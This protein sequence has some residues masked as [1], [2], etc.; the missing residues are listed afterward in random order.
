[1]RKRDKRGETS[2]MGAIVAV[3]IVVVVGA[4]VIWGFYKY[5]KPISEIP[6][7]TL[8]EKQAITSVCDTAGKVGELLKTAYCYQFYKVGDKYGNCDYWKD[9]VDFE[10]LGESCNTD[11][12]QLAAT[13]FCNQEKLST[14]TKLNNKIC[15]DW[16]EESTTS[17]ETKSALKRCNEYDSNDPDRD[18]YL[19]TL[20]NGECPINDYTGQ[21]DG[22]KKSDIVDTTTGKVC[23]VYPTKWETG[24]G[25]T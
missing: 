15:A 21:K 8:S 4:L 14:L 17:S 13:D 10:K 9:Y 20:V 22:T 6:E 18:G 3:I 24:R 23:C 16:I 5:W 19:V 7:L 1:M 12:V 2:P 11:K 25:T